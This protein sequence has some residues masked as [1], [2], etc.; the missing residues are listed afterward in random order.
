MERPRTKGRPVRLERGEERRE[1][2]HR[3]KWLLLTEA[4]L[5][6]G[7]GRIP[8]DSILVEVGRY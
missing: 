6:H 4:L 5:D 7:S 2:S 1:R 8:L 3:G